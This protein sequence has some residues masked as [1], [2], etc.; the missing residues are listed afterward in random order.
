MSNRALIY[1]KSRGV[2]NIWNYHGMPEI[3]SGVHIPEVEGRARAREQWVAWYEDMTTWTFHVLKAWNDRKSIVRILYTI[4]RSKCWRFDTVG[5]ESNDSSQQMTIRHTGCR[6]AVSC[7]STFGM[8][9]RHFF[10]TSR[11]IGVESCRFDNI[12]NPP[13]ADTFG[14]YSFLLQTDFRYAFPRHQRW[15]LRTPTSQHL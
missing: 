14:I 3:E 8:T 15:F 12:C 7:K 9:G 6:F 1:R 11:S 13:I 5:L 2:S 10:V 4:Q